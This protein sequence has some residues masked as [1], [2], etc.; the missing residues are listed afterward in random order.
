MTQAN[1]LRYE[2]PVNH[3]HKY[4]GRDRPQ[5]KDWGFRTHD[6]KAFMRSTTTA[7]YESLT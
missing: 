7:F 2:I 6:A 3:E 5:S 1:S 4:K